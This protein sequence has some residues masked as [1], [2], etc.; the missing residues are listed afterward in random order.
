MNIVTKSFM[1]RKVICNNSHENA[2]SIVKE[3]V[4]IFK[5]TIGLT[6]IKINYTNI[7]EHHSFLLLMVSNNLHFY[8][9][10]N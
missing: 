2:R 6:G 3:G 1:I 8:L 9:N 4:D 7:H 10:Y 5:K